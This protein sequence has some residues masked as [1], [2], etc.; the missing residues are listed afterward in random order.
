MSCRLPRLIVSGRGGSMPAPSVRPGRPVGQRRACQVRGM[1]LFPI[2]QGLGDRRNH[3]GRVVNPCVPFR[4]NLRRL[5][6]S[7]VQHPS[8]PAAP[9][10]GATFLEIPV[11]VP[12]S[13]DRLAATPGKQRSPEG[14]PP[15]PGKKVQNSHR[16][17]ATVD[18]TGSGHDLE[19]AVCRC[20]LLHQPPGSSSPSTNDRPA[21][22]DAR[23]PQAHQI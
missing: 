8:A 14:F 22:T 9:A 16:T 5:D 23:Y 18:L 2:P 1:R 6:I 3:V 21:A 10:H 19:P 11:T 20:G 7:P 13:T 12:I 4:R 17:V 15:P